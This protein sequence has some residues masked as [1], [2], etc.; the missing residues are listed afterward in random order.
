MHHNNP[1]DEFISFFKVIFL[2]NI[3]FSVLMQSHS[4]TDVKSIIT[5]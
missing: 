1:R 2:I 5:L 3:A 4:N